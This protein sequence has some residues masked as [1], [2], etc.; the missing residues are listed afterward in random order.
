MYHSIKAE[1]A[2]MVVSIQLNVLNNSDPAAVKKDFMDGS[3]LMND[4]TD[5]DLTQ[6]IHDDQCYA[7]K[8]AGSSSCQ[9]RLCRWSIKHPI[10][11]TVAVSIFLAALTFAIIYTLSVP[12]CT[13]HLGSAYNFPLSYES[14][15]PIATNNNKT[16]NIVLFGDSLI[17][18][19]MD[20]YQLDQ[21]MSSYLPDFKLNVE[22]FGVNADNIQKMTDRVYEMIDNTV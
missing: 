1:E 19:P 14:S 22:N 4:E 17:K 13:G 11:M 8:G 6:G 2:E 20:E 7:K 9:W 3:T 10:F 5:T 21:K 12:R 16:Y 15:L 18:L